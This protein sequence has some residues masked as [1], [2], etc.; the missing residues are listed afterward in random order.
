MSIEFPVAEDAE[1][2]LVILVPDAAPTAD[3]PRLVEGRSALQRYRRIGVVLAV[4][5]TLCLAAALLAAHGLR[6]GSLPD[7][8][9]LFGIAL[10]AILWVGVFHA[11]GLYAPYDLTRFEE[12]RRTI[13]A[14]GIGLVVIIMLTFWFEVYL[15]RSWMAVTL[16]IALVLEVG[17]RTIARS[18][19]RPASSRSIAGAA[20]AG[21]RQRAIRDRA[22]GRPRYTWVGVPPARP[23]RYEQP[24]A[25]Q[26][27]HDRHRPDHGA[28]AGVPRV[29]GGLR[30]RG[31]VGRLRSRRWGY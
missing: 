12:F 3:P 22:D 8:G 26:G 5:D 28:P 10:G 11:L 31:L 18:R 30:L 2:E 17:A 7:R 23:H 6:F 14:V 4:I 21:G 29:R 24:P 13:S 1:R 20:N 25:D 27:S 16:V 15:S 9:Y 19:G